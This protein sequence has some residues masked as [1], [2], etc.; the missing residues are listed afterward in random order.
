[1]PPS[2]G[3]HP[4]SFPAVSIQTKATTYCK[5]IRSFPDCSELCERS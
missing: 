1:V 3:A 4:C 5:I 2:K